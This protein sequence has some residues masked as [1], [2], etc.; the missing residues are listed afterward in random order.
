MKD[1]NGADKLC[2]KATCTGTQHLLVNATCV[3]DATKCPDYYGS[4]E[5]DV[6]AGKEKR[7]TTKTCAGDTP[8][9]TLVGTCV[10]DGK[11]PQGSRKDLAATN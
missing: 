4:E 6:A 1:P 9:L 2:T 10:A 8:F 5:V 11:C 3:D 7:C